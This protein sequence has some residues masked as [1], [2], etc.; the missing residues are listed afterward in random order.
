[1][2]DGELIAAARH[3]HAASVYLQPGLRKDLAGLFAAARAAGSTTSLDPQ[4]DPVGAW[5]SLAEVLAVT[6]ILFVNGDEDARIDSAACPLVV[7]KRGEEGAVAR[8]PA[9]EMRAAA[10]PVAMVD[11][12]G[13]G[14]SFDAGYLAGYLGSLPPQEALRLAVAC[15]SLSTRAA[16]GTAAQPTMDEARSLL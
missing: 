15:G 1:M 8:T 16:G 11:A 6:D 12:V 14:D 9:G 10:A 4:G 5:P 3:V 13:A 2:I 7:V